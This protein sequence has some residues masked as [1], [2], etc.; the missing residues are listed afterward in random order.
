MKVD[1]NDFLAVEDEIHHP[2]ADHMYPS[3]NISLL[4]VKESVFCFFSVF[5][6]CD[7]PT[8][9]RSLSLMRSRF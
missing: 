9:C 4:S 5:L 8:Q 7:H 3:Q 1:L 2:K 6:G